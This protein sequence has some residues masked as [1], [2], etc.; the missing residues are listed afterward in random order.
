LLKPFDGAR[1]REVVERWFGANVN[2]SAGHRD[3]FMK[4]RTVR[5]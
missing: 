1:S 5:G 4:E 3:L 2:R